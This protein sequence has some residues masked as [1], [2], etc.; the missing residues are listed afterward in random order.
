MII[1]INMRIFLPLNVKPETVPRRK[2]LLSAP[3]AEHDPAHEL[4]CTVLV[5]FSNTF[6]ICPTFFSALPRV[7]RLG[8]FVTF[9]TVSL[10]LPFTSS[11]LPLISSFVLGFICFLLN[12]FNQ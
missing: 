6:S 12:H 5:Y 9:P 7:S 10:T 3:C 1:S 2:S 8:L 4:Q 11:R